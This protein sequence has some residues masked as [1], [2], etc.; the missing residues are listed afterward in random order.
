MTVAILQQS[1]SWGESTKNR[2]AL[3]PMQRRLVPLVDPTLSSKSTQSFLRDSTERQKIH[4]KHENAECIANAILCT[5]LCK[6]DS[7]C[8]PPH[9]PQRTH[10]CVSSAS[11]NKDLNWKH[12][13]SKCVFAMSRSPSFS[14]WRAL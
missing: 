7:I 14:H 6:R 3:I 11:L 12:L 13:R 5:Q 10:S 4:W 2:A 8:L 1:L 9:P